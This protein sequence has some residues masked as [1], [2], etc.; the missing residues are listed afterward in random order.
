MYYIWQFYQYMAKETSY[1]DEVSKLSQYLLSKDNEDAKRQLLFPLFSRL[2]K[3][4]FKSESAANGADIYIEGQIIVECKTDFSQ[5]VE[6][7]Y[8]GLH[9]NR[10]HGLSYN[11]IMVIA[12]NFCC[13]WKLKSIPEY[14]VILSRTADA[15]KAPNVVGKENARKT[16]KHN[17]IEILNSAIYT[18]IP[19][20]FKQD[21][22]SGG[23]SSLRESFEILKILKNLDVDRY[24]V[25]P[26][27][28]I[29]AIERIKGFFEHPI[30]AVHAFYAIIPYWDITST[31]AEKDNG[32]LI[33]VGFSGTK[34]SDD[35]SV[36][37][38]HIRDFKRFVETQYIFTNEGSGLTVD[39]YFSRFD[40][41]LATIDP[42]Y[43]KQHGIFFTD[44][45]LSR[46]A[47]WFAK[48][49]FPGN[50]DENY[51]VF[52]PAA[53][54]GNLVSSWRGK[55]KHKIVSELQPDLLRIIDR[56]MR[57]DP[58][59]IE[60][61]FTIIPK[62]SENQGLNF[63]D[64]PASEYMSALSRE[65]KLKNVNLDKPIAFLLN[66]PYKNTDENERLRED[67]ESHYSIDPSILEVTGEDA[68]KERYLGFLGQI[69]NI[70]KWQETQNEELK[71]VVMVFTPTSWL[72][73]RPTYLSFR[74]KW[75]AHFRY[76]SGFLITSNEFFKLEGKWPLA[77][78][79]WIYDDSNEKRENTVEVF[80]LTS[81]KRND[82]DIAWGADDLTLN[83]IA[84]KFLEQKSK[85][86]L[87]NSRGDIRKSL[88][89][90]ILGSL[91][92]KQTRYDY[93]VAK[94]ENDKD[95]LVSGFPLKDEYNHYKLNRKCGDIRGEFVGFMDD[96]LPVR[97][98]QDS[99]S[100][101]SNQPDRIW[102]RLDNDFKGI[103]KTK[104]FCGGPDNRGYCAYDLLS[105]KAILTWFAI[106]KTLNGIYPVWANQYDIWEPEIKLQLS[107]YWHSLCFAFVLAENR[108]IVTKFEA[109]NP[110]AGAPEIFVDNPLCPT[111][112]E[113]FWCT[114]LQKEIVDQPNIAKN[115]V[116]L[117]HEMYQY[118][119]MNYCQ[120]Q[121]LY[122]VGLKNEPYFKYFDYPD[123]LTPHSGLIQIR[124][125]AEQEN[126]EDLLVR[127]AEITR[128]T[129]EV[130]AELYRLLVNEFKYFE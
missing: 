22:Y 126:L 104:A 2:F 97:I 86:N 40:E 100:R 127:F 23:K 99:L 61:G 74:K 3:E 12:H 8:Q 111:N 44:A 27:N 9:Y 107:N 56:R 83:K 10:K 120:G 82:L 46:Y 130:K 64:K 49:H 105:S 7:F 106:T 75:D 57:A 92:F 38:V 31:I 54:S 117:I 110:V 19:A 60:T 122:N 68:G 24:L 4:K 37:T 13:I 53:G 91:E 33:L 20:D 30:D 66:P 21:A 116:S 77:F 93:S 101:M 76:H 28:F 29:R 15:M 70:C 81:L 16:P 63:L 78:T 72:I 43:V 69:L 5:W 94:K 18:L 96:C 55:L 34:V 121:W 73:P 108:C 26:H 65:L 25:T 84:N 6:G 123:F 90:V 52:D 41:V 32:S 85:L 11:T 67:T 71:P 95:K 36:P 113:S 79:I 114:T 88:P 51:I 128:A 1:S 48:H 14:A 80:D 119:N 118:W 58:F 42:E 124:K 109:D 62:T 47:L 39:Y 50:I 89:K 115:L 59:H 129:K 102:F 112:K 45:N 103:N 98:K 125:Y 87:D 17:K 35:I